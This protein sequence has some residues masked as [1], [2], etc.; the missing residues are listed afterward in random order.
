MR[1][2]LLLCAALLASPGLLLPWSPRA[3]ALDLGVIGPTTPIAEPDLLLELQAKLREKARS[4]ELQQWADAA[5]QR[6]VASIR[7]PPAVPGLTRSAH[8]R[9]FYFDPTVHVTQPLVDAQGQVLVAAGTRVNPLTIVSLSQRL[10]FFDARDA[11]QVRQARALIEHYDGKVKPILVA[12]SYLDLMR[13]WR[14]SVYYDQQG[15]LVQKLGITQVPALVSQEGPRLRID[16]LA[17][18]R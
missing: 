6:T 14:F 9:S 13:Q 16:E 18:V 12:G 3:A 1:R 11:A 8:A 15:T 10:L 7:T 2:T 4:G 17:S 5:R